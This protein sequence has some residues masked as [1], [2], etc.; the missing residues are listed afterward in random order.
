M[1]WTVDVPFLRMPPSRQSFC[2]ELRV[3]A[4]ELAK[5]AMRMVREERRSQYPW[6]AGTRKSGG[7]APSKLKGRAMDIVHEM[8]VDLARGCILSDL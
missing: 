8:I 6:I 3:M 7:M 5:R 4:Y 1:S 2:H